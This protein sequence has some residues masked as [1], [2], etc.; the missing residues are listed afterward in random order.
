[1]GYMV[2]LVLMAD[3]ASTFLVKM[4]RVVVCGSGLDSRG[5]AR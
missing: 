2:G 4:E 3:V 5:S 1:M